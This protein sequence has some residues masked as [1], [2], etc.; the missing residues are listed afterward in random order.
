MEDRLN[1]LCQSTRGLQRDAFISSFKNQLLYYTVRGQK[2][3]TVIGV[4][5]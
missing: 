2:D 1:G 3:G 4:R 5:N